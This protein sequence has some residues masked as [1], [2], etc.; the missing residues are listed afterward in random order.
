MQKVRRGLY[1]GSRPPLGYKNMPYGGLVRCQECGSIMSAS[2]VWKTTNEGKRRYYYYRCS[3]VIHKGWKSCS[4]RQINADRFHELVEGNLQRM[5]MD[6]FYLKG[7]VVTQESQTRCGDPKGVE[8]YQLGEGLTM[9]KLQKSLKNFNGMCARKTGIEKALVVQEG[10]RKVHYAKDSV[11]IEFYWERFLDED[12]PSAAPLK[13][14][15]PSISR[16]GSFDRSVVAGNGTP[17]N[18]WCSKHQP[19][20]TIQV[21]GPNLSHNYWEVYHFK[22]GAV[23]V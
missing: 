14:K 2:H 22:K 8:P 21:R 13:K 11:S 20:H 3:R 17:D 18:K 19:V 23:T 12:S 9:E 15:T 1:P 5:S 6:P 10:I 16:G 7:V 4:T